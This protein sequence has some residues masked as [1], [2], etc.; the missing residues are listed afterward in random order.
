MDRL[1]AAEPNY[2]SRILPSENWSPTP[3]DLFFRTDARQVFYAIMTAMPPRRRDHIR[4]PRRQAQRSSDRVRDVYPCR[5]ILDRTIDRA[6][7]SRRQGGW[8]ADRGLR[9]L[10]A[11]NRRLYEWPVRRALPGFS[12]GAV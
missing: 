9:R 12:E 10:P 2:R 6:T 5:S 3:G 4:R 7:R 8:S 1:R 11:T